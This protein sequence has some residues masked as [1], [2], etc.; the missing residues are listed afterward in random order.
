M[1]VLTRDAIFISHAYPEDNAFTV[2]RAIP[3][4]W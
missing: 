4:S 3:E 1:T 2:W